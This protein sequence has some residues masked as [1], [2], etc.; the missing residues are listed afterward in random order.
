MGFFSKLVGK[1]INDAAADMYGSEK[2]YFEQNKP[3]QSAPAPV[4]QQNVQQP[5][6]DSSGRELP[7]GSVMPSEYNQ[8]SSGLSYQA[9]FTQIFNEDLP[10]YVV[11]S[12]PTPYLHEG[13]RFTFTKNGQ[14]C[15]I[16]EVISD[17]NSA[18]SFARKCRSEGMP[19]MNFY[20]DHPGWWNTRSYVIGKVKG[21]LGI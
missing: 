9:Y 20:H 3:Q 4:Q 14:V 21:K 13:T 12:E 11:S 7:W 19:Y 8:Y 5:A 17:R 15:L 1:V 18:W 6:T 10:D 2:H 16:V